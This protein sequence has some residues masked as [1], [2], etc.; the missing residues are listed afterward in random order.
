MFKCCKPKERKLK[1]LTQDQLEDFSKRLNHLLD[2]W[3]SVNSGG[4][5]WNS[6]EQIDKLAL[7]LSGVSKALPREGVLK[8]HIEALA[9]FSKIVEE[10][11]T[12]I[13]YDVLNNNADL[14]VEEEK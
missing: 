14:I 3:N 13:G 2:D 11:Y 10:L 8:E 12:S 4:W 9:S 5:Y 1:K 7:T 6:H